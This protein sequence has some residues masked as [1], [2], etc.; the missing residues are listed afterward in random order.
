MTF[1]GLGR[2][3]AATLALTAMLTAS[4]VSRAAV[5]FEEDFE[6]VTLKPAVNENIPPELL[7]WTDIPPTGWTVDDSHVPG[8]LSG[9]DARDG[10]TEWAGWS[11]ASKEFW[12]TAD[13][14]RRS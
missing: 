9:D 3:L 12:V 2:N 14:Q 10:R 4:G 1:R 13:D 6:G 11:F 7:G 8:A 5:F